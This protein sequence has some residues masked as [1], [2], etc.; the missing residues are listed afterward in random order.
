MDRLIAKAR[1]MA[2]NTDLRSMARSFF[3][4]TLGAA[5]M[6]LNH[7]QQSNPALMG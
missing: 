4:V 7:R 6:A 5:P 3:L 1:A 2:V